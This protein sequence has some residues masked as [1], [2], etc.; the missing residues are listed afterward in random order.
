MREVYGAQLKSSYLKASHHGR[1]SGLN[2]DALK[3]INPQM[4]FVSVGRKPNTDASY[5]YRQITGN[6]VAS[7]RY[8]GDIELR[9]HDNGTMEWFV[10]HNAG[11]S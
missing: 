5:R 2:V 4:T 11:N 1:G 3:L 9:L 7:T 8:Y 10:D 6:R